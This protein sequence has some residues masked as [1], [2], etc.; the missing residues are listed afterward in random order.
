MEQQNERLVAVPLDDRLLTAVEL[1][2]ADAEHLKPE[3]EAVVEVKVDRYPVGQL[4]P[5]GHVAR[6]LSINAGP[7]ADL[8]LLLTKHGLRD[9]PRPRATLKAPAEK[10]RDDLTALPTLLLQGW[11]G[12]EAPIL[13]AVSLEQTESGH[14]LWLHAPAIAERVGFGGALDL[15]LR[16]QG[17][18]LC[19]G[20][21]WLPLLTPALTKAAAFKAGEAQAALSVALEIGQD[22]ALE[23]YRF[24]RSTIRP[25]ALVDDKAL[26]ALAE[27]KP[28][29]RTTRPPSRPSRTSC[30]CW[31]R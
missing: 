10:E 27:R 4:P 6:S 31:S 22:G 18:A 19:V 11:S 1:P 23:H 15:Y 25:D 14:R 28:K 21:R 12:A 24:S 5:Q 3:G 29:A 16:D 20:E 30:P 26:Q 9:R 17:E 2:A 8:D 7:E 13:P